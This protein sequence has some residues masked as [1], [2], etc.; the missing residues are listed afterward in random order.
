MLL[1]LIIAA[2]GIFKAFKY[3]INKDLSQPVYTPTRAAPTPPPVTPKSISKLSLFVP[4]WTLTT[5]KI[6]SEKYNQII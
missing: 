3:K 2:I 4:Y 1:I 6:E 5:D